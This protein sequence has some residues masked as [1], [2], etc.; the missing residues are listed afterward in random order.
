MRALA[1][2]V[3]LLVAFMIAQLVGGLVAGSLALISDAGH[4]ATDALGVGLALVAMIVARRRS[5]SRQHTYGLHRLEILAA[6][7]NATLLCGIGVYLVVESVTRLGGSEPVDTTTVLIVGSAGLVV[8]VIAFAVLRPRS[9]ENLNLQGA[10]LEVLA[11]LLGSVG[12]I[13]SAVVMRATHWGWVDPVTALA[14]GAVVMPRALRL[15][16]RA[17]RVLLE[18]APSHLDVDS[19]DRALREVPGVVDLHDLHV[20]TLTAHRELV[21]AHLVVEDGDRSPSAL[22]AATRVLRERFGVDHVT[23]Q[24]ETRDREGCRDADW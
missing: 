12:V 16:A 1:I 22:E 3:L 8:N 23:L 21:T 13:V 24:V 9:Q 18:M 14:I 2:V 6:L 17:V 7:A 11:D 20:W 10:Y 5:G 4:M 15:G 19:V